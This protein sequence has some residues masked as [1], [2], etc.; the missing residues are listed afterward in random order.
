MATP[1]EIRDTV[2]G[3]LYE[4]KFTTEEGC[5][6]LTWLRY[7]ERW[8][9][10]AFR[11][12]IEPIRSLFDRVLSSGEHGLSVEGV[13]VME[14]N[15]LAPPALHDRNE[16][17]RKA[18][19]GCLADAYEKGGPHN[20]AVP[21]PTLLAC[22]DD[23]TLADANLRVLL[24]QGLAFETEAMVSC[25]ITLSGLRIV[26]DDRERREIAQEL[27]QI[28]ALGPHLRGPALTRCFARLARRDG[29][30]IAGGSDPPSGG[31]E[32]LDMVIGRGREFYLVDS[33]WTEAPVGVGVVSTL[34][35]RAQR[36][37][38]TNGIL[39]SMSGF[40]GACSAL[41]SESRAS[42]LVL[43][44]GPADLTSLAIDGAVL[45][46]PLSEKYRALMRGD[47]LWG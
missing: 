7:R 42:R 45:E 36:R 13:I 25:R 19:L 9:R 39:V 35:E 31:S 38:G 18:M 32:A 41:V 34:V 24:H 14:E 3:T 10:Q 15:G 20:C 47:V 8:G 46:D 40:D 22:E 26:E 17:C 6:N 29:W 28:E 43:L 37:P 27:D 12:A 16:A 33:R 5:R 4:A 30:E 1:G 21:I 44:F 23:R 2:L 11:K